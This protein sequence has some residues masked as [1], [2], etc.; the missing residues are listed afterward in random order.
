MQEAG[1]PSCPRLTKI[2][3]LPRSAPSACAAKRERAPCSGSH[4][5][6][7]RHSCCLAAR[8]RGDSTGAGG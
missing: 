1:L 7:A 4:C 6:N 8:G 2:D 3:H 5:Y